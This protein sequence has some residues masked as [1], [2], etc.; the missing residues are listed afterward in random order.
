M[1]DTP[2]DPEI[3]TIIE[4]LDDDAIYNAI[5]SSDT[6]TI[7]VRDKF[8]RTPLMH[9]LCFYISS[10]YDKDVIDMA[11]EMIHARPDLDTTLAFPRDAKPLQ[12]SK[13][14]PGKAVWAQAVRRRIPRVIHALLQRLPSPSL[15]DVLVCKETLDYI[16][17]EQCPQDGAE[18]LCALMD[19]ANDVHVHADIRRQ[20]NGILPFS[21]SLQT[22]FYDHPNVPQ[23]V[24]EEARLELCDLYLKSCGCFES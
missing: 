6:A 23:N 22:V 17:E 14:I 3:H 12:D 11:L 8:G 9:L 20:L 5:K 13:L 16:C 24:Q 4:S 10:Y 19:T 2:Y 15:F 7:N 18:L 21:P 1:N